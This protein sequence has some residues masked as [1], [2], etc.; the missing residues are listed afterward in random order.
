MAPYS[1]CYV[2][3]RQEGMHLTNVCF[4]VQKHRI[5]LQNEAALLKTES[6]TAFSVSA[7]V[8]VKCAESGTLS[9]CL[10]HF[11]SNIVHI[12]WF[13]G[14]VAVSVAVGYVASNNWSFIM[15]I[16][17]NGRK[18]TMNESACFKALS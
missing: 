10:H 11:I 5:N 16:M 4:V 17:Y 7:S 18:L 9:F 15:G 3:F 8:C 14:Y 13:F 12:V 6:Y 1:G 2:N